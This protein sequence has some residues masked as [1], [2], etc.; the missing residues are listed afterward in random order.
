MADERV[1]EIRLPSAFEERMRR[2]LGEEYEAY[3]ASFR[4]PR[5][6]G[7]CINPSRI[8]PE[9]FERI[10]PFEVER[11]PWIPGGYFYSDQV[12][13]SRCPLYQAGVYYLQ[14]P[15]AMTPAAYLPVSQDDMVLDLCAAPGGKA[16]AVGNRLGENGFL[17]ANDISIARCRALLRNIELAGIRNAVVTCETPSALAGRFPETF[18]KV[19]LDAPCSGEGMF[20]KDESLLEDWSEEKSRAMAK[21]QRELIELAYGMIRPGGLLLYSTCTFAPE[22]DEG[23]VG[24]LLKNHPEAE[25]LPFPAVEGFVPG[26]SAF[27]DGEPAVRNCVRIYPHR[28]RAEG[29]F[30]ALIRKGGIKA[31]SLPEEQKGRKTT[32]KS[33]KRTDKKAVELITGFFREAGISGLSGFPPDWARLEIRDGKVYYLPAVHGSRIPEQKLQ[34]LHFLR[35]GL[36]LGELRKN[37]FEPSQPLAL[38]LRRKDFT[39]ALSF[40]LEDERLKRYLAGESIQTE[41]SGESGYTL[42]CGGG[43]PLGFGKQ[44][45]NQIKN[46]IPAGWRI[47]G[48]GDR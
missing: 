33:G 30:M 22:E 4:K 21:L 46:K 42:I 44:T 26:N 17:A 5:S 19:V 43:F 40:G 15:G 20:R 37:R 10:V 7:L 47:M 9:E 41:N 29:Q 36:H 35:Y 24:S 32:A 45:G 48:G 38:A 28:M 39:K 2:M 12:R 31:G 11:I 14:D 13:P 34:G 23:T 3:E 8:S 16:T 27:A 25:T 6:F 18:D 1:K